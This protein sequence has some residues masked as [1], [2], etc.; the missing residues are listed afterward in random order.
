MNSL[1][2]FAHQMT[3]QAPAI[4]RDAPDQEPT[5]KVLFLRGLDL[6]QLLKLPPSYT[7]TKDQIWPAPA[8][9]QLIEDEKFGAPIIRALKWH[10]DRLPEK[11]QNVARID[12]YA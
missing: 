3:Q 11:S 10:Y 5:R 4:R 2:L 8:Y 12:R 7:I 1:P 6:S 9:R